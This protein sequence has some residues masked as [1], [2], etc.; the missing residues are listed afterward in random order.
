MRLWS[1]SAAPA[2]CLRRNGKVPNI[3]FKFPAAGT[4]IQL[5]RDCGRCVI[6]ASRGQQR[7]IASLSCTANV[8]SPIGRIR[9]ADESTYGL[10]PQL[11]SQKTRTS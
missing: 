9:T 5:E 10:K 4:D 11:M 6:H 7:I 1:R 2:L 8:G 3:L